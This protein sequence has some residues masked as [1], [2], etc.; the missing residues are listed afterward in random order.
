M[1]AGAPVNPS[2]QC[3]RKDAL[4]TANW[5]ADHCNLVSQAFCQLL[6]PA[7][8]VL[9]VNQPN[10]AISDYAAELNLAERG[11][12]LDTPLQSSQTA[13]LTGL[14]IHISYNHPRAFA[15]AILHSEDSS[16]P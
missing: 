4:F 1:S 5:Q 14:W 12:V 8:K 9:P 7:L 13:L 3:V 15:L 6:L 10:Q 11:P 2:S 16:S